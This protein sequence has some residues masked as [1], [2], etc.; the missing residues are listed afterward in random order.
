MPVSYTLKDL[1]GEPLI[2]RFYEPEL[3]K[4]NQ[5][6]F[7]IEKVINKKTNKDGTKMIRVKWRGYPDK[8]N[9]WIPESTNSSDLLQIVHNDEKIDKYFQYNKDGV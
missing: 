3:Q 8:F 7:R 5:E 4:T 2:G 9:Q 1:H 6:V